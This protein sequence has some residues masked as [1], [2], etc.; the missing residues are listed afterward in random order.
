MIT[1]MNRIAVD[2]AYAEQFEENFRDR[3]GLVDR[4]PGF[5]SNQLL[6][7]TGEGE[8]YIVLTHWESRQQ[9]EA[10]VRSPEFVQG[11]ARSSSLPREAFSGPSKLELHEVLLDSTR[12]ELVPEPHGGPFSSQHGK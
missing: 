12:P 9:F 7:P 5:I 4:M 10:W 8:P 2:P 6:R 1:T 11:H 3:A